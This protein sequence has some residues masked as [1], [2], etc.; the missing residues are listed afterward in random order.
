MMNDQIEESPKLN[1]IIDFTFN[2]QNKTEFEWN[3]NASDI[4]GSSTQK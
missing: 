4:V 2:L 3:E 1:E